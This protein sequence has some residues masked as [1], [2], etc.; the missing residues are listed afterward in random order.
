MDVGPGMGAGAQDACHVAVP[1]VGDDAPWACSRA[2]R[3]IL[4]GRWRPGEADILPAP[5]LTF[6]F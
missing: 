2:R 6:P 4:A 5:L 1:V 3:D